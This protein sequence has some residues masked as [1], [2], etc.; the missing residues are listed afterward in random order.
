MNDRAPG[1]DAALYRMLSWFSPAFPIGAFGYSHGLEAAAECG[2]V[3]DRD[4]LRGWIATILTRGTGRMDADI[5]RDA[6]RAAA[7]RNLRA[8]L[9]VNRLG[10]AFRATSEMALETAAQGEAFV[11]TCRAAWP[12]P[13]L[14]RWAEKLEEVGETVCHPAAAGAATGC[15]GIPLEQALT[16]YLQAMTANL[17]SAGMR[18]G[19]VGQTDGQRVLAVLEPILGTAVA[20]ALTR[21]A[22]AF[23]GAAIAVDL[24]S[25]AHETQYTRLFRS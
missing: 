19:I 12:D 24:V 17:V 25:I 21:D 1:F 16:G 11:A 22:G 14:D 13:L 3:R 2:L 7:A 20:S 10:L 6:H 18:L 15:A 23:G 8:L 5:L 9:A 4:T